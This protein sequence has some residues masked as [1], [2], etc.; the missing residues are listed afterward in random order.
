M[1][2]AKYLGKKKGRGCEGTLLFIHYFLF[3]FFVSL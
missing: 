2:H 3:V 1:A